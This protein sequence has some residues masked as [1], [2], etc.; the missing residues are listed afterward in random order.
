LK[1]LEDHSKQLQELQ[2][3]MTRL[4]L[5]LRIYELYSEHLS[6]YHEEDLQVIQLFHVNCASQL[7]FKD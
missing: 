2:Y 1:Q 3:R 5:Y 7:I 4:N 6:L